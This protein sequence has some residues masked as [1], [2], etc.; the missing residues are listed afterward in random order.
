MAKLFFQPLRRI[1]Q[2]TLATLK[3][4]PA[5]V[6]LFVAAL[7]GVV[8]SAQAKD[9]SKN[10]EEVKLMIQRGVSLLEARYQ[11][12]TN[13]SF[14]VFLGYAVYKATH[15]ADNPVVLRG[16]EAAKKLAADTGGGPLEQGQEYVYQTSVAAQLLAAIDPVLYQPEMV[17]IL[18]YYKKRQMSKGSFGYNHMPYVTSGQGDVS[19][20]QYA[21]LALWTMHQSGID[22]PTEMVD[23]AFKWL[24]NTQYGDGGFAYQNPPIEGPDNVMTAVGLSATMIAGDVLGILRTEGGSAM[25]ALDAQN[26]EEAGVPA[27]FRRVL[28]QANAGLQGLSKRSDVVSIAGSANKWLDSHKYQ[29]DPEKW[30]YY[31]L[32]SLERYHAFMEAMTGKR[33]DSPEWYNEAVE[34]MLKLQA[35]D[36]SWGHFDKAAGGAEINTAFAVL[37]L[38]RTTQDSIGELSEAV[39]KGGFGLKADMSSVNVTAG[40]VEDKKSVS[41]IDEAMKMLDSENQSADDLAQRIKLDIDPKARSEQL[42]RFTRLLRSGNP[43]SRRVAAKILCRGDDLEM[44]PHLIYALGDPDGMTNRYAENSLRVLSRQMRTFN[45]PSD[46]ELEYPIQKRLAAQEYWKDWYKTIRPDYVFLETN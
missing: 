14:Q 3:L 22:V 24:K 35:Q 4:R 33:A 30:H 32:Y 21:L 46:T 37:F 42:E 15:K 23:K 26:G 16:I 17:K 40:G 31:W 39:A 36:G 13:A 11:N 8:P 44:V 28:V 25:A 2:R 43:K 12:Q 34:D 41:D 18:E 5:F 1:R 10:S 38:L 9:Y 27:A 45:I 19:Q 6:G 7:V 20:T 29:R